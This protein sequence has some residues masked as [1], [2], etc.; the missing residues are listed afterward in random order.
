MGNSLVTEEEEVIQDFKQKRVPTIK[1]N[2]EIKLHEDDVDYFYFAGQAVPNEIFEEICGHFS[3]KELTVMSRVSKMWY[4]VSWKFLYCLSISS[5]FSSQLQTITNEKLVSMIKK[6]DRLRIL[7]IRS[8]KSLNDINIIHQYQPHLL[9]LDLSNCHTRHLDGL[10]KVLNVCTE[11]RYLNLSSCMLKGTDFEEFNCTKLKKLIMKNLDIST[12][13]TKNVMSTIASIS[14]DL[15][16]LDLR[17]PQR[18]K[19]LNFLKDLKKLKYLDISKMTIDSDEEIYLS[20][21]L[22]HLNMDH[23]YSKN[24]EKWKTD[25]LKLDKLKSLDISHTSLCI[26]FKIDPKKEFKLYSTAFP[27]LEDFKIQGC[28]FFQ[29]S[30]IDGIELWFKN[31]KRV[32]YSLK[33]RPHKAKIFE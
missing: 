29:E 20:P 16:V 30:D 3:L 8:C 4:V 6:C 11:L 5:E 22:E 18:F 31:L 10:D 23:F 25:I 15:E 7:H 12:I 17:N 21:T 24:L 33:Y 14:K 28:D 13:N 19:T 32:D 1:K 27:L 9:E 2:L 26:P